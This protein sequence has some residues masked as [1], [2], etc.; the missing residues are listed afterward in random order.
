MR[1]ILPKKGTN[2]ASDFATTVVKSR[3]TTGKASKYEECGARAMM[4]ASSVRALVPL[5]DIQWNPPAKNTAR[6]RITIRGRSTLENIPKCNEKVMC[7]G[8]RSCMNNISKYI[9]YTGT[10]THTH[11]YIYIYIERERFEVVCLSVVKSS[12]FWGFIQIIVFYS[13]KNWVSTWIWFA[14]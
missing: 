5:T 3:Y 14:I 1:C 13:H 8:L 2:S 12:T 10:H 7:I 9:M 6:Q 4:G 11:I